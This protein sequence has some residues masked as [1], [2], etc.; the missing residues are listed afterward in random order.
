MYIIDPKWGNCTVAA[1]NNR[2]KPYKNQNKPEVCSLQQNGDE[3]YMEMY[4]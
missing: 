1:N 2:I 3:Q 4:L